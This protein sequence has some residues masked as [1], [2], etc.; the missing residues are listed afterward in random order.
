MRT[1]VN[2][3]MFAGLTAVATAPL[4]GQALADRVSKAG[5][6]TVHLAFKARDGVCGDGNSI[7][8][9]RSDDDDYDCPCGGT[10][11]V[12]MVVS[13]GT[14]TSLRTSVGGKWKESSATD[15]GQVGA[16]DAADYFLGLAERTPGEVGKNAILPAALADSAVVWRRLLGIAKNGGLD[17]ERRREATFW[18]GQAAEEAAT[19]GLDTLASDD[20]G[21]REIREAAVFA[22]SQRPKD[23]GVPILV[24]I[25]KTNKDPDIRRKALFWLG[26]SDDPRALAVFEEILGK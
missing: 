21:D 9:H 19:R 10:V 15:L 8:T 16:A 24:R 20:K 25:A 12:S 13:G 14:I 18:V 17:R 2:T 23:E 26:Q 6:G 11:R 5:N 4:A 22:L 7:N 3:I 1:I